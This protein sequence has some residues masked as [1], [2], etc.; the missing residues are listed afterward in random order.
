[1]PM[2]IVP[3]ENSRHRESVV[4]LWASVFGYGSA[5]NRPALVINKKVSAQDG[6]FFVAEDPSGVAVGSIMGGYDGHRGWIYS[7]AVAPPQRGGGIGR[8]LVARAESELAGLGC[9][10]I[11]LQI[12][13][14]NAGVVG[15]Y[16]SLGYSAEPRISMGKS[17]SENIPPDTA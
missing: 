6:L 4:A 8:A 3:F 16:E 2:S 10:K 7:L 11:N 5:R 17:L 9:V 1:M 15:F 13:Q 12:L 14:G